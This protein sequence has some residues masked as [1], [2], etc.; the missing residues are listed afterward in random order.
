M[1]IRATTQLIEE[2]VKDVTAD[3]GKNKYVD[4]AILAFLGYPVNAWY[5][6]VKDA[7][8]NELTDYTITSFNGNEEV[9]KYTVGFESK[10]IFFNLNEQ[11]LFT[12]PFKINVAKEGY[13]TTETTCPYNSIPLNGSSP[14]V[15][16][17]QLA[18]DEKCI[19]HDVY[20]TEY[21]EIGRTEC[22]IVEGNTI[23][24][25]YS[26]YSSRIDY[27]DGLGN[28]GVYIYT[29]EGISKDFLEDDDPRSIISASIKNLSVY[30]NRISR[31]YQQRKPIGVSTPEYFVSYD[32]S[33]IYGTTCTI[34]TKPV[35][36]YTYRT[37]LYQYY[38]DQREKY[39][40][41][42]ALANTH[43][44]NIFDEYPGIRHPY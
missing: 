20:Y 16:E 24:T 44:T 31:Y 2:I 19:V 40:E 35:G 38:S 43:Q 42:V 30:P 41:C 36:S 18:H 21:D 8:G 3:S 12:E 32:H 28:D 17:V 39:L 14:S 6:D 10:F 15:C 5:V 33:A 25:Y 29:T 7:E 22:L 37:K 26:S 11:S 13:E 1:A 34:K 27:K 4:A 23:W 9:D